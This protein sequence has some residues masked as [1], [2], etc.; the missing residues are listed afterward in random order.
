MQI[1]R[2]INSCFVKRTYW[3][4]FIR[5]IIES[6]MNWFKRE[7]YAKMAGK[8]AW[9][10]EAKVDAEVFWTCWQ[11]RKRG[12]TVCF[13]CDIIVLF[14]FRLGSKETTT[15]K[16]SELSGHALL[17][18]NFV[19]MRSACFKRPPL[20]S[21][22]LLQSNWMCRHEEGKVNN[23]LKQL[24]NHWA[25]VCTKVSR[26]KRQWFL[27][28]LQ[29]TIDKTSFSV[30]MGFFKTSMNGDFEKIVLNFMPCL[31]SIQDYAIFIFDCS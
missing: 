22:K 1:E 26:F 29:F 12:M 18:V 15:V 2:E 9:S 8:L 4:V 31:F 20:S 14:R 17:C 11:S 23:V 19:C 16:S 21:I 25:K 30:T 3:N 27:V 6:K 5:S 7:S 13:K 24:D 10:W 28:T